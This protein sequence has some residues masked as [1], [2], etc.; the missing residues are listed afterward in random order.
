[1]TSISEVISNCPQ[2][3]NNKLNLLLK[4]N[5]VDEKLHNLCEGECS[6]GPKPDV[7]KLQEYEVICPF[8]LISPIDY[9]NSLHLR[10][11]HQ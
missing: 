8:G 4:T 6:S 3:I 9:L 7:S 11:H 1:M 2:W 5:M 10:L